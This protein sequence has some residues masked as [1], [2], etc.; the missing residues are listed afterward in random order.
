MERTA[1]TMED[2]VVEAVRRL[3]TPALMAMAAEGGGIVIVDE[4]LYVAS[5][6]QLEAWLRGHPKPHACIRFEPHPEHANFLQQAGWMYEHAADWA[7][8]LW[9]VAEAAALCNRITG[10]SDVLRRG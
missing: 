4:D 10:R 7:L 8:E 6:T 5:R 1:K 9:A 2:R 3:E